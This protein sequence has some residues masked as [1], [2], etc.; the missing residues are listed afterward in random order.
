MPTADAEVKNPAA[1]GGLKSFG[2]ITFTRPGTY[3]YKVTETGT[4]AGVTNDAAAA[5]G[6]NF[7]IIV[8]DNLE[9][10][11]VATIDYGSDE[12]HVTFINTY[13][14]EP[15]KVSFPVEKVLEEDEESDLTPLDITGKFTF[16]LAAVTE[17]APM[18]AVTSQKNP[19]PDGGTVT[20]GDIEF[21]KPGTYEYKVTET[22]EV[23]FVDNDP[24]AVN[25][26]T[27]TV[28]V[29]DNSDGTMTA[30]TETT[31]DN[32]VIFINTRQQVSA[33]VIKVWD[34][35]EDRYGKRPESLDVDLMANGEKERTVTLN[36]GNQWTVTVKDLPK[37][38]AEG[39]EIAYTWVEGKMPA[40][41]ELTNEETEGRV[42][43]LTNSRRYG[44]LVIRKDLTKYNNFISE[45]PEAAA[46]QA[47]FI[48]HVTAMK[49]DTKVYEDYVGLT[50]N[51]KEMINSVEIR[52]MIPVGAVVT[53]VEDYD[54]AGYAVQGQSTKT[55]TITDPTDA[56]AEVAE[57]DFTN[58]YDD[59][60]P[61]GYGIV[62]HY[63]KDKD[64]KWT[65][66]NI[67]DN[68]VPAPV[69]Q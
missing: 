23:A 48:F 1:D 19:D 56:E 9:G 30:T 34:D 11:L 59:R 5:T 64:G 15:V 7:K 41:Y 38:D 42:T 55:V 57:A 24:E 33:K 69:V 36:A 28:T 14:V 67:G 3:E 58:A 50:F 26:K 17:G 44:D 31:E 54:G 40:G 32:P 13:K 61:G 43:T 47:T 52:G 10:Q 25:G 4:V 46:D 53:V 20:F 37:Y 29:T 63:T 51:G 21:K 2:T 22:G 8:A 60:I 16:D 49:G 6:K 68:R 12:G 66:E 45:N 18:P 65:G 27:V 39:E 62:N 35:F